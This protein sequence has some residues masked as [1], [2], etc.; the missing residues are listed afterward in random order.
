MTMSLRH[1]LTLNLSHSVLQN[2]AQYKK[3]KNVKIL[4]KSVKIGTDV[5]DHILNISR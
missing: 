5:C 4:V 1:V 2:G 3:K